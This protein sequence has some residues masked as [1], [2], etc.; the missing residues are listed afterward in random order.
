[1]KAMI[2]AAGLGTRMRPLTDKTPKPLLMVQGKPLIAHH[3]ERLKVAG[4]EH[5]VINTAYL[6]E[7]IEVFIHERDWGIP[8][9]L[10]AEIEPLE[11]AGGIINAL[12][13]LGDEPFIVFN[14]DVWIDYPLKQ[15]FVL[16]KD[17]FLKTDAQKE[18][19]QETK[20]NQ[21][22]KNAAEK[23]EMGAHLVLVKNPDHHPTGDF[24]LPS[25]RQCHG[26]QAL[27]RHCCMDNACEL[28]TYSGVGVYHP[29]L[30]QGLQLSKQ[31]LGPLIREWIQQGKVTG[32][33]F[34]GF[35]LDVGTPDRLWQLEAWLA[36]RV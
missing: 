15:L 27:R 14:G 33:K 35:W 17:C 12:P 34:S 1:M 30:F 6:A 9:S 31:P 19:A 13:L 22:T 21:C 28:L 20:V 4:C 2:L 36:K 7:Q 23:T 5:V 25:Q 16:A 10:S 18:S 29:K 24:Y 3:I 11:T 26:L 8:I 32:E